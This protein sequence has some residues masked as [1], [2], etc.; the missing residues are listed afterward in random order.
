MK[1]SILSPEL[2]GGR[3][4]NIQKNDSP[5][6]ISALFPTIHLFAPGMKVFTWM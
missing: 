3:P 2:A 5:E 1:Y 4:T 6:S